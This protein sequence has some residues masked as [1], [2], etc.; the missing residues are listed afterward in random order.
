MSKTSASADA[1]RARAKYRTLAAS[2]DRRLGV[3][4]AL[5]R[6]AVDRLAPQPGESI[7][8]VG[9][10]TG[11]SFEPVERRIGSAG[12]LVGIE[13]SQEMR[14]QAESRVRSHGWHNVTLIQGRAQEVEL[15]TGLDAALLVLTH[16]V[17]RSREAMTNV[18]RSL[19][20]GGRIVAAGSRRPP[21]WTGPLRAYVQLKARRYVTTFEGF[22]APWSVL[23]GL[24]VDLE[25]ELILLGAAYIASGAVQN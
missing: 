10:G 23:A 6:R 22:D 17:M 2:Y 7:L 25:V 19:R 8:D 15:P 4:R 11:L 24:V 21:R 16:D 3:G 12:S 14:E 9:C 1:T 13:L 5:H 18:I 20:P